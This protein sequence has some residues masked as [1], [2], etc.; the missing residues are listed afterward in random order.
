[1]AAFM[2][3][4]IKKARSCPTLMY[5]SHPVSPTT[6]QKEIAIGTA[7]AITSVFLT[8]DHHHMTTF[9][10]IKDS[11]TMESVNLIT[12]L[13]YDKSPILAKIYRLKKYRLFMF[14]LL[15]PILI[16]LLSFSTVQLIF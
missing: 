1:M 16:R 10:E 9:N 15:L 14:A 8:G 4:P 11:L 3:A 13:K 2:I 12:N 5:M 7:M 6:V